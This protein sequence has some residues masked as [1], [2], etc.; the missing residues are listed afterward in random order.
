MRKLL[1]KEFLI[2]IAIIFT[3][4]PV[5]LYSQAKDLFSPL[6]KAFNDLQPATPI[7]EYYL[8]R[9]VAANILSVYEPYTENPQ[10]TNYVNLICQALV[11]NYPQTAKYN[12][13]QVT[14]LNSQEFSA[15]ATPG[16]HIFITR[17]LVEAVSNEDELAGVIAH[18]L[19]HIILG[20]GIKII[21]DMKINEEI[22]ELAQKAAELSGKSG[23]K[24]LVF[25]DS[26]NNIFYTMIKNGYTVPQ[27][28]EADT[29]AVA[30][31]A[32]AKYSPTSFVD[33]LR[34]FE[35]NQPR[36]REG[37]GATH[38]TPAQRIAN[39][40]RKAKSYRIPDTRSSRVARFRSIL[41][42]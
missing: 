28:F 2:L 14:I 19:A 25:R 36:L 13:Y 3:L 42:K 15:F 6:D 35:K 29:T 41:R 27:E 39:V 33:L 30:I 1:R 23:Q 24:I 11:I 5:F 34:L 17:G 32:S 20:H 10:L 7:D 31:L 8:G 40:E 9:A 26:V 16:G 21:N 18:E 4:Q 38:P 12:G 37:F 22:D